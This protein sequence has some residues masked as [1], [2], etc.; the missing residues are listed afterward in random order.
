MAA[1]EQAHA[2]GENFIPFA[3]GRHRSHELDRTANRMEIG[4]GS[5]KRLIG[6][7][8]RVRVVSDGFK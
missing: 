5:D 7:I 2:A 6:W 8:L 4:H 1:L 3:E